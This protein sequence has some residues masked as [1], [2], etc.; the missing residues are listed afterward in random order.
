MKAEVLVDFDSR[1]VT[2]FKLRMNS[3]N[4]VENIGMRGLD[5]ILEKVSVYTLVYSL[6]SVNDNV[7]YVFNG[8][9]CNEMPSLE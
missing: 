4:E 9:L 7:L 3:T 1:A 2:E 5:C 8:E 6:T